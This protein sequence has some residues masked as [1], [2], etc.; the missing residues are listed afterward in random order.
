M[1]CVAAS[2]DDSCHYVFMIVHVYEAWLPGNCIYPRI[3][4]RT[5]VVTL[6]RSFPAAENIAM[7]TLHRAA[8]VACRLWRGGSPRCFASAAAGTPA[9]S[10]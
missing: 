9:L 5:A 3:G 10:E 4:T 8:R 6:D 1:S 2:P 7:A